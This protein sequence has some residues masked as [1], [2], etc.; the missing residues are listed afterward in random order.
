[1]TIVVHDEIMG[2]TRFLSAGRV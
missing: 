1:M 2:Y